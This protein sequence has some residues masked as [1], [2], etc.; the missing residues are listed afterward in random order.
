MLALMVQNSRM[1]YRS[2]ESDETKAERNGVECV[3]CTLITEGD[4]DIG[5]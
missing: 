5:S 3:S 4:S 2:P 1:Y